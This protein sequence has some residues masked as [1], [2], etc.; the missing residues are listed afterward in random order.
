MSKLKN[1]TGLKSGRLTVISQT[2]K[3]I[4]GGVVW[5]CKCEC[6]KDVY[7]PS[8]HLTA[9]LTKSCGCITKE[10]LKSGS[11][12]RT[13]GMRRHPLYWIWTS[14]KSRCLNKNNPKY[15]IY[16]GRGIKICPRWLKFEGFNEDMN[17]G[18]KKGLSIDRINTNGDYKKKN[19]RWATQKEQQ[20]N[21]RNNLIKKQNE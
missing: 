17:E 16:G 14:M 13:H 5:L 8:Y 12:R 6:G 15:S 18:Y 2:E 11:I 7:V 9:E 10:L 4:R 3:R 1:I 21:R 20:N 19:C